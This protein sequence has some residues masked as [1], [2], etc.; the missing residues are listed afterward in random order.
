MVKD[1]LATHQHQNVD[2]RPPKPQ[3]WVDRGQ[4]EG[5]PILLPRILLEEES[6]QNCSSFNK[7]LAENSET[8]VASIGAK[9]EEE[10]NLSGGDQFFTREIL[11]EQW[12]I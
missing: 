3:A 12:L 11:S 8:K 6:L 1:L 2:C 9:E 4:M 5:S 10:G 7:D